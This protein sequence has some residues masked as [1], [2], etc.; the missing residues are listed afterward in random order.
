MDS[1]GRV[2]GVVNNA[3]VLRDIMFHKMDPDNFDF[4]LDVNLGSSTF[5][6]P[7]RRR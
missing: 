5:R 3:G 7:P 4:V 6:A 2:D 1:F